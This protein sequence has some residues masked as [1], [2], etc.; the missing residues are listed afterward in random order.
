MAN[1]VIIAGLDIGSNSIKCVVGV[2]DAQ[3][4]VDIIGTGCATT[5]GMR[6]GDVQNRAEFVAAIRRARE[7][8]EMMAGVELNDVIVS[9]SGI[10]LECDSSFGAWCIEGAEVAETD[11]R[12]V[13]RIARA[14][15]V[16][17]TTDVLFCVP[18]HYMVDS[19]IDIVAPVGI[20]GVRLEVDVHLNIG[21]RETFDE[22]ARCC[23]EAGLS[24]GTFV[25][26]TLA[27]G[28]ALLRAEDREMGIALVDIGGSTTE[29]SVYRG[30]A[31]VFSTNL[32][33]G[34]ERVT[35]DLSIMFQ[36]PGVEAERLKQTSGSALSWKVGDHETV[37][38]PVVG[39]M[40][41][42]TVA[43]SE[44]AQVCEARYEEILQLV[45]DAIV[46]EGLVVG[47]RM[48]HVVFTGGASQIANLVDLA[49]RVLST[50]CVYGE[51]RSVRG[52]VDM[53][54]N[55]K[56]AAATGIV[57]YAARKRPDVWVPVTPTAPAKTLFSRLLDWIR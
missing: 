42:R 6:A 15:Q 9:V 12:Q 10:P 2:A 19:H 39:G 27:S 1:D 45:R 56:Y 23:K 46:S 8:A 44:V 47:V 29:I 48:P 5:K 51:P 54:R 14:R 49:E 3:G 34:G 26:N 30:G 41:A 38:L 40:R 24:V 13:L 53:V 57:L 32:P 28:E 21:K 11:I 17:P 25:P 52:M 7:E 22:I 43:R 20:R 50:P 37:E 31:L 4:G 36:V 35:S 16:A 33:V 55:P 18:G